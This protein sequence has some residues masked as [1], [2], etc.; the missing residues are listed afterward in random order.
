MNKTERRDNI[1][2]TIQK[3]EGPVSASALAS[4]LQVSRQVIVGDIA[5][6]RASGYQI[7][8]TPTG[9]IV[10]ENH[11]Y[12]SFGYV[13][14]IACKHGGDQLREELY[15]IVDFGG[16]VLDVTIEHSTYGQISGALDIRSRH[17]TDIFMEKLK[18]SQSRPLSELT[19]G[20]HL[21]RIG[22]KD[23]TTFDLILDSLVQKGIALT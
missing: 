4:Q 18:E 12:A 16:T 19:D 14:I 17:D 15:T 21:H 9:Y 5:L 1:L 20:I 22:C 11:A 13:G 6:L 10:E 2:K 8:A 23:K 7:S 3:S